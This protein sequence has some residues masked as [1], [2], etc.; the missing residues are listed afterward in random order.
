MSQLSSTLLAFNRGLVSRLGLARI[1]VKRIASLSAEVMTN[2]IPR[3]LGS[4]SIRPGW[5]YLGGTNGFLATKLIPFVFSVNDTALMELTGSTLRVWV[6]D[7]LVTRPT[8]GT[9]VLNGTFTTDLTSWT[10]TD[11]AGATSSWLTG[12]YLQLLGDGTNAAILDQEVEVAG[13]DLGTV[14]ALQILI[15]KGPVFCRVGSVVGGEGYISETALG[16]GSHSLS[17]T[18]SGNFWIR[19]SHDYP[20]QFW[21]TP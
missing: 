9:S 12:G 6:N 16:E 18:P 17:F 2:F 1:D 19:F 7:A 20:V 13:G 15:T 14:H 10:D 11:E 8:V 21:W 4:M 3:V 5:K